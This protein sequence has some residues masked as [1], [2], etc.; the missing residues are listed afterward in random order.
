[1]T[2]IAKW[3]IIIEWHFEAWDHLGSWDKMN[4]F[5]GEFDS[6]YPGKPWWDNTG[7]IRALVFYLS[8]SL[9]SYWRLQT[10]SIEKFSSPHI[11]KNYHTEFSGFRDLLRLS[12]RPNPVV[13]GPQAK[14]HCSQR[15][16]QLRCH[17]WWQ[18]S[19]TSYWDLSLTFIQQLFFRQLLFSR[20]RVQ[21]LKVS[22]STPSNFLWYLP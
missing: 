12:N 4:L 7:N 10:Y 8:L 18:T 13:Q 20:H 21:V 2:K 22:A 16:A 15:E 9:G 17:T 11:F 14:N 19:H 3:V 1:M 5:W 6:G